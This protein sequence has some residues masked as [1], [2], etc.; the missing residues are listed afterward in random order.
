MYI[1]LISFLWR[2]QNGTAFEGTH[3]RES[4]WARF[5]IPPTHTVP[6]AT[7]WTPQVLKAYFENHE[8]K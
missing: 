2:I 3:Q 6:E 5:H 7:P 8:P 4:K 1:L